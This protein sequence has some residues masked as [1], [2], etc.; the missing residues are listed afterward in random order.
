MIVEYIKVS[1]RFRKLCRELFSHLNLSVY[2]IPCLHYKFQRS[3]FFDWFRSKNSIS[4]NREI[5]EIQ[6]KC[7][8]RA[9]RVVIHSIFVPIFV[10]GPSALGMGESYLWQLKFKELTLQQKLFI[11]CYQRLYVQ[12]YITP[13][14]PLKPRFY[15][16]LRFVYFL[17]VNNNKYLS[18]VVDSNLESANPI[19]PVEPLKASLHDYIGISVYFVY[20][21]FI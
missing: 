6:S 13:V 2:K 16:I 17:V 14:E 18:Y 12:R 7:C 4:E 9:R 21:I 5:I 11:I 20:F 10:L 19:T 1:F 3:I 15:T 8:E